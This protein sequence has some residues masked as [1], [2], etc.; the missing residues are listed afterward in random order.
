MMDY[1]EMTPTAAFF[2]DNPLPFRATSTRETLRLLPDKRQHLC[3]RF[4]FLEL[5]P[6]PSD[7]FDIVSGDA[8]GGLQARQDDLI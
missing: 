7:Y 1:V 2:L 4:H 5:A 6:T 3:W 8:Q